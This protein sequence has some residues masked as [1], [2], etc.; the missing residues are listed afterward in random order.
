M[1]WR[2]TMNDKF[3]VILVVVVLLRMG[4]FYFG[5]SRKSSLPE[6]RDL[7]AAIVVGSVL[8]VSVLVFDAPNV[9]NFTKGVVM[10]CRAPSS[11]N[12]MARE[13]YWGTPLREVR[14]RLSELLV[15]QKQAQKILSLTGWN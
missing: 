5:R 1:L 8:A 6:T 4:W 3:Q 7:A 9:A 15:H 2:F 13:S 11:T 14:A 10:V 12:S